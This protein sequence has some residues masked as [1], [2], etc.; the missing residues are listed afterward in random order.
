M[1]SIFHKTNKTKRLT[2][3]DLQEL[4]DQCKYEFG[5]DDVE[6]VIIDKEETDTD[7]TP[8]L[9]PKGKFRMICCGRSGS[10]KTVLVLNLLLKYLKYDCLYVI[11]S[12]AKLQ[13]KYD[14]ICDLAELFPS[15]FKIIDN[16]K[17]FSL[18]QLAKTKRNLILIDDMQEMPS[19]QLLKVNDIFC[20]G[21][22]SNCSVIYL[23][24]T[25]YRVPIRA[26]GS[27]NWFIFFKVNS[28]KD[29]TRI[30]KDVCGDLTKES[31]LK[32]FNEATE[33]SEGAEPY[34]YFVVDTTEKNMCMRYRKNFRQLYL[35]NLE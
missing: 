9:L 20:R 11:C 33:E 1:T 17:N 28:E 26:R 27:A 18:K 16:L 34:S 3:T 2:G 32:L 4:A 12:T 6:K 5:I 15:K 8:F 7:E 30:H 13:P 23:A 35:D 14:L 21:R 29:K 31:F 10:G 22:H 25:Y 19:E 24:Q